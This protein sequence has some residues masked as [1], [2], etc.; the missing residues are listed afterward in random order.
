MPFIIPDG[1]A[2]CLASLLQCHMILQ[3]SFK[4]VDL[5]F[6]KCLLFPILKTVFDTT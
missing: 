1:K 2:E 6:K 3:K 4:Y 5:K